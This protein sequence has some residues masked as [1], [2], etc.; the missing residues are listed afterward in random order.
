MDGYRTL[1][2]GQLVHYDIVL[3]EEGPRAHNVTVSS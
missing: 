2:E 1:K 3:T